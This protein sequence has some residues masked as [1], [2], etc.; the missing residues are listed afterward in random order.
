MSKMKISGAWVNVD[1]EGYLVNFEDW[2]EQVACALAEREGIRDECPLTRERMD[3]LKFLR[4]YYQKFQS[5]PIIQHVCKQVH[6]PANC[7]YEQFM[8]PI[9]AWKIAGLPKPTTEV[10][11][12]IRHRIP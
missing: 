11:A 3:I 7:Q 8:D 9:Q 1:E 6:Q 4:D 2:N 5:F 12:Y 10:Y